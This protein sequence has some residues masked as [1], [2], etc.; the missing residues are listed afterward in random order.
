MLTIGSDFRISAVRAIARSIW[1]GLR[2]KSKRRFLLVLL[3]P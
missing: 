2:S 3:F 1:G